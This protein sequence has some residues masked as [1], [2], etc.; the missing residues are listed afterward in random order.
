MCKRPGG[1]LQPGRFELKKGQR[2]GWP[3]D[4]GIETIICAIR[5]LVSSE[6]A[7]QVFSITESNS[8]APRLAISRMV[9]ILVIGILVILGGPKWTRFVT[10]LRSWQSADMYKSRVEPFL[11]DLHGPIRLGRLRQVDAAWRHRL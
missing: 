1:S 6:V 8:P 4:T 10:E 7:V 9:S 3:I 2:P 11:N 5:M